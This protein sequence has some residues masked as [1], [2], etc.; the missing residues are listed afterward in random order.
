MGYIQT[1]NP[2]SMTLFTSVV[3]SPMTVI[4]QLGKTAH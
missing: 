3:A 1:Y 4:T 2:H